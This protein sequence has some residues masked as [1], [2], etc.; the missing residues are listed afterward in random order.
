M[1]STLT[2]VRNPDAN[3]TGDL[4]D[5]L[6]QRLRQWVLDR[7]GK[8]GQDEH[9]SITFTLQGDAIYGTNKADEDEPWFHVDIRE[10]VQEYGHCGPV[11]R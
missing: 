3:G 10:E 6:C 1:T 7:A 9:A 5:G 11:R 4:A 8:I 2:D